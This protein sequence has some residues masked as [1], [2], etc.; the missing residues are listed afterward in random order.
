MG[1]ILLFCPVYSPFPR[2]VV[3]WC[4]GR[5]MQ[6]S[7]R[8]RRRPGTNGP[9]NE[10]GRK[11]RRFP[12]LVMDGGIWRWACRLKRNDRKWRP[13]ATNEAG[14]CWMRVRG[15][16]RGCELACRTPAPTSQRPFSAMDAGG[17]GP[18]W[19]NPLPP[20]RWT[21]QGR[22]GIRPGRAS[23]AAGKPKDLRA[24]N[25]FYICHGSR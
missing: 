22:W 7:R 12:T 15:K 23:N 21:A 25:L 18:A 9:L 19:S 5:R 20:W 6:A 14:R 13:A 3:Y 1:K 10:R 8:K 24:G 11:P 4:P 2:T 17:R 16:W